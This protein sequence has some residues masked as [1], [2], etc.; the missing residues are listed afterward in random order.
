MN[1][2]FLILPD[3]SLQFLHFLITGI[4][5]PVFNFTEDVFCRSKYLRRMISFFSLTLLTFLRQF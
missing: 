3:L 5:F 2:I 4:L 1:F